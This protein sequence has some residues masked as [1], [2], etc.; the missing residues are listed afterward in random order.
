M[1]YAAQVAL[2]WHLSK[3]TTNLKKIEAMQKLLRIFEQNKGL[4]RKV[5][6]SIRSYRPYEGNC[7]YLGTDKHPLYDP[8][9]QKLITRIRGGNSGDSNTW[10]NVLFG[11]SFISL[12]IN[13]LVF[14][15]I[16]IACCVVAVMAFYSDFH[17]TPSSPRNRWLKW[18][19]EELSS[20][21]K[22]Y[23]KESRY[24]NAGEQ[25]YKLIEKTVKM[26]SILW[27][28]FAFFSAWTLFSVLR[29]YKMQRQVPY[30]IAQQML[31]FEKW[32]KSVPPILSCLRAQGMD[33]L[34]QDYLPATRQLFSGWHPNE[35]VNKLIRLMR[36]SDLANYSLYF[37]MPGQVFAAQH[38]LKGHK[39]LLYDS[40]AE[41]AF[42]E[43]VAV[44]AEYI[45]QSK[46][47]KNSVCYTKI[48]APSATRAPFL[49]G[50]KIW[51]PTID[52]KKAISNDFVMK[53]E[54]HSL[55]V[56]SGP[57]A[58]GKSVF[59]E[60]L[61][62]N[63][64]LSQ[65]LGISFAK[66]FQHSL[67]DYLISYEKIVGD[68]EEGTSQYTAELT[69]G[70]QILGKIKEYNQSNKYIFIITDE[71]FTGT[72]VTE[73]KSVAAATLKYV[74]KHYTNFMS[75]GI[76]HYSEVEKLSQESGKIKSYHTT[77][78]R[79]KNKAQNGM[80]FRYTYK[81]KEGPSTPEGQV[82]LDIAR[83][84][85][86]LPKAI[87]FYAQDMLAFIDGERRKIGRNSSPPAPQKS[88]NKRAKALKKETLVDTF[89]HFEEN[90][91]Y[92][93][94]EKEEKEKTFFEKVKEEFIATSDR[95]VT[96]RQ[97]VHTLIA[98]IYNRNP[99]AQAHFKRSGGIINC[100]TLQDLQ[101]TSGSVDATNQK[102]SGT[103]FINTLDST[104]LSLNGI[105]HT[106]F[107]IS[108]PTT[109]PKVIERNQKIIKLL[110]KKSTLRRKLQRII[111]TFKPYERSAI[112]LYNSEATL[113]S[114]EM[115][116]II[117]VLYGIFE[118]GG[119]VILEIAK[120]IF[121]E[122]T[123]CTLLSSSIYYIVQAIRTKSV[124]FLTN[125]PLFLISLIATFFIHYYTYYKVAQELLPQQKW[126]HMAQKLY[127]AL[128]KD[129]ELWPLFRTL[130]PHTQALV[131]QTDKNKVVNELYA[132][133]TSQDLSR[134]S[135]FF[136]MTGKLLRKLF[137]LKKHRQALHPIWY[138][139]GFIESVLNLAHTYEQLKN[140]E[141]RL[142]FASFTQD[143][144]T[145]LNLQALW[146]TN[147]SPDKAVSNDIFLDGRTYHTSVLGGPNAN[148][149][150][151]N[152][153]A[154][155]TVLLA[156]S[157]G[158]ACAQKA[159]LSFFHYI[160]SFLDVKQ[161]LGK[162]LSQ[163]TA[164]LQR[165]VDIVQALEEKAP[166]KPSLVILDEPIK[167]TDPERYGPSVAYGVIRYMT[168]Q[169]P[170][171]ALF[172]I[173]HHEN[174]QKMI[175]AYPQLSGHKAI[176]NFHGTIVRLANRRFK[177]TFK[178]AK[179]PSL[180][181]DRVGIDI[182]EQGGYLP[183]EVIDDARKRAKR[184]EKDDAQG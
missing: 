19:T 15:S 171:S 152:L 50:E 148:G 4:R 108:T 146:N 44:V 32:V 136:S 134:Y 22:E 161:D 102:Q 74:V 127:S 27:V 41:L 84:Y 158:L 37:S 87:S 52:P 172:V 66:E 141:N 35:K 150:T 178:I 72:N 125:L 75:V 151:T 112:Y 144:G 121:F 89:T 48:L 179:G 129:P 10:D 80:P 60:A 166:D 91:P 174:I 97:V 128:R 107:K 5:L 92:L 31:S 63:V 167:G 106:A 64:L 165:V 124:L 51:N 3:P 182:A 162:Q 36:S 130:M 118:R 29:V 83:H 9:Y 114:K 110:I 57:N 142:C 68:I 28:V 184:S 156:Q 81:I 120:R 65:T 78:T 163:Y 117:Q 2:A 113:W 23:G 24:Y 138:E 177:F 42:I 133:F 49:Q 11:F 79:F 88:R 126:M 30:S 8:S 99:S 73:G 153:R 115:Q 175:E 155:R 45:A 145:Y 67:F 103:H 86:Y 12:A 143:K 176:H 98:Q 90:Y 139:I 132:L 93:P 39:E 43:A 116:R 85:P 53:G 16:T 55:A 20:L 56:M 61:M 122:G 180:R 137:I 123:L 149:K 71:L 135:I 131:T 46:K 77:I 160:A 40:W 183:Q 26:R 82:G 47:H 54:E 25:L 17:N 147:L 159:F 70:Q 95:K 76:S 101:V 38:L 62:K 18:I 104:E 6:Q 140:K 181:K 169:F 34:I 119:T 13:F 96:D 1:T 168:L 14:V 173:T 157:Y 164:E 33:Q 69:R 105:F 100:Q 7:L 109:D 58:G 111:N 94:E 170:Q 59:A 154:L 21:E